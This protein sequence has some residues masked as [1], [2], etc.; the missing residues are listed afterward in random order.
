[1]EIHRAFSGCSFTP[2]KYTHKLDGM[3]NFV[4]QSLGN[5]EGKNERDDQ[6]YL[7]KVVL[8]LV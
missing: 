2:T 4:S 6:M 8:T 3:S 7:Q 5:Y 1:M